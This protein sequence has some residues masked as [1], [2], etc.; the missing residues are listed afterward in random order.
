MIVNIVFG[1]LLSYTHCYLFLCAG[2]GA[3]VSAEHSPATVLPIEQISHRHRLFFGRIPPQCPLHSSS[4]S[5]SLS[6]LN[7]LLIIQY[8]CDLFILFIIYLLFIYYCE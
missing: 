8:Y 4:S 5:E 2:P 1:L 7:N 3:L 6:K